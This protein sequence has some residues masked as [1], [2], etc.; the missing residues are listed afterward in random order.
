MATPKR[1]SLLGRVRRRRTASGRSLFRPCRDRRGHLQFQAALAQAG[2]EESFM[3]AVAQG[4]ASCI[5]NKFYRSE[6]ELLF[7]C[8]QAMR[9]EYKAILDADLILQLDD[10]AIAENWDMIDP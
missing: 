5:G 7:A 1:G 8:A 9:E 4:S 2:I 10:Q 3:T 6:E